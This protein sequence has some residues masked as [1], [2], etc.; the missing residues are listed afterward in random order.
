MSE[1]R[2]TLEELQAEEDRLRE[3]VIPYPEDW[4]GIFEGNLKGKWFSPTEYIRGV[5]GGGCRDTLEITVCKGKD[6]D[7]VCHLMMVG[8]E[9]HSM[10]HCPYHSD[11]R[12]NVIAYGL[13]DIN[14]L[15]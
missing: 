8:N 10:K 1:R 14:I 6:C 3:A 2:Y 7:D 12:M 11:R 13:F 15:I 9:N 4:D 5:S